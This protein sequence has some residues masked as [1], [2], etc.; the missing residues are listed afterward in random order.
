M[1]DEEWTSFRQH[2]A[3]N[4][5]AYTPRLG[6]H[7]ELVTYLFLFSTPRTRH[8]GLDFG[9]LSLH[10]WHSGPDDNPQSGDISGVWRDSMNDA[11]TGE[12][13][14][15]TAADVL[16]CM[17]KIPELRKDTDVEWALC[18]SRILK[19]IVVDRD[20][21]DTRQNGEVTKLQGLIKNMRTCAHRLD[22]GIPR[23]KLSLAL[24]ALQTGKDGF[25]RRG[26]IVKK[27]ELQGY[28][29]A[30]KNSIDMCTV[31]RKKDGVQQGRRG[32]TLIRRV[33]KKSYVYVVFTDFRSSGAWRRRRPG[34][35]SRSGRGRPS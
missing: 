35:P 26:K 12:G 10:Q 4:I 32:S 1:A 5:I 25:L 17:Q 14:S 34:W 19:Q 8:L 15:F 2:A 29:L 9:F 22:F 27:Q 13:V 33:L 16:E 24:H 28:S 20:V 18:V 11:T 7:C 23:Q 6:L 30:K 31:L 21:L 3:K